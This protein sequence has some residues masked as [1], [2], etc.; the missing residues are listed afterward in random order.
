[1]NKQTNLPA[2]SIAFARFLRTK[3]FN[4]GPIDETELLNTIATRC[5]K[6]YEEQQNLYKALWVKNRKQF[7][8]FDELYQQYWNEIARAENSKI[9]EQTE[10]TLKKAKKKNT[11]PT[12]QELKSWLFAGRVE[13]KQDIAT[14]SAF[15]A[16]SQKDFSMFLQ[17]EHKELTQILKQIARRLA[18][19]YNRR[20]HKN[21]KAKLVDLKN[22][23][24]TSLK[25]GLEINR[26]LYKQQV[27]RKVNIVLLCDV[28][29]SMELY[30]RFLIEFMYGFQQVLRYLHTFIFSTRLVPLSHLLKD[31]D[32]Q[33]VLS[34][35]SGQVPYWS[36]GT[37]IGASLHQFKEKYATRLLNQRTVIIILSDGW[38][39][40]DLGILGNTMHY[41]QRKSHK[42][43]WLNPLA[44]NPTYQPSTKAMQVCLPYIDLF[45]SAHNVSS[46][47]AVIQK[48]N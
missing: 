17:S 2:N 21:K 20:Y 41:L 48:F 15:E 5:P 8:V 29:R 40:G 36:G 1:V 39:T 19:K 10:E 31:G 32:Y 28:S 43:I 6:S 33:K 44:G 38:D 42:L 30:S 11:A 34:N 13:E 22:T 47:K 26:V 14:Y 7:V 12:L 24:K 23:I 18:N 9:K 16:L 27:K 25:E 37:K 45:A 4:I 35:L 46:L 3:D